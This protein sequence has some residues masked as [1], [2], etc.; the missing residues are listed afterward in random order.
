VTHSPYAR[1]PDLTVTLSRIAVQYLTL[2]FYQ[3][4]EAKDVITSKGPYTSAWNMCLQLCEMTSSKTN[5]SIVI[6]FAWHENICRHWP[7]VSC[8]GA[9]G[10]H[11][12]DLMTAITDKWYWR[13]G[14]VKTFNYVGTNSNGW[15]QTFATLMAGNLWELKGVQN[16]DRLAVCSSYNESQRDALF[17]RFIW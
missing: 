17:L 4:T 16:V 14:A 11:Q 15:R 5:Y 1:A 2:I 6:L 9:N 13:A 12:P 3:H 10:E 7:K 8:A